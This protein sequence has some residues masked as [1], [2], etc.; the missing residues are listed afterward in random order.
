MAF[1]YSTLNSTVLNQEVHVDLFIPT[2]RYT[3]RTPDGIIYFLHGMGS[4]ESDFREQTARARYSRDNNL[5]MVFLAAYQSFFT[6]MKY[7]L[8]Y[9]TYITEELPRLIKKIYGLSFPREKTYIAGLSMGGYGALYVGMSRPDLYGGIG[10][11]SGAVDLGWMVR[12]VKAQ[13]AGDGEGNA[14][15]NIFGN[16]LE[17]TDDHDLFRLAEKIAA[18]P[19]EEQPRIFCCCGRQDDSYD[20]HNQNIRLKEHME[21]LPLARYQYRE[22]D[23]IHEYGVWDRGLVHAISFF[24][25]NDYDKKVL[26][27]WRSE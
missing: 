24:L 1:I 25:E 5:A 20:I 10:G 13:G 21:K 7:G 19:A 6:D 4:N 27:L 26:R 3:D 23:G 18:L 9:F 14:F 12:A 22:W 15:V 16:D 2:D 11:F 17:F 8:K